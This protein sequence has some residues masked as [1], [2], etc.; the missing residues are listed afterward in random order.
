MG[1]GDLNCKLAL[2]TAEEEGQREKVKGK[3]TD[4]LLSPFTLPL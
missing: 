1:S 4:I 2:L 3:R